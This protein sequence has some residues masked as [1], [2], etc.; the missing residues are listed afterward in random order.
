MNVY[1]FG[2]ESIR[3]DSLAKRLASQ[4]KVEG[5]TFIVC[6]RP[7]DIFK[8]DQGTLV[9]LDVIEGI[10]S[11]VLIMDAEELKGNASV[12]LHDFDLSFFLKLMKK[13]GRIQELAIVGIPMQGDEEEI[14]ASVKSKLLTLQPVD[15]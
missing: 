8:H 7:E 15:P 13:I 12:T 9:I 10:E 4:M 3:E 1:C 11:V 2:N 5:I 6:D 14:M